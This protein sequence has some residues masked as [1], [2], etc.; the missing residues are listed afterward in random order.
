MELLS[1]DTNAKTIKGQK[2]G[3]LT[4]I[5]YLAPFKEAGMGNLCPM[6]SKGCAS[7]CLFTA[8]RGRFDNVKEARIKKTHFWFQEREK[9]LEILVRDIRRLERK[10]KKH[11]YRPACRLNGTSD[12]DFSKIRVGE[13]KNIYEM[14]PNV[15]FYGYSK[16]A[17]RFDKELTPN[18]HLTFSRSESNHDTAIELAKKGVNVAVVF[19][20]YIPKT[21]NGF[22]V[23][24][25]DET[26]LRFLDPKGVIC[27][28]IAKGKA[29]KDTSGFVVRQRDLKK[30]ID[31]KIAKV[32]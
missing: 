1:I 4:G 29:K 15:Q 21:W 17:S 23:F 20:K 27:G 25:A 6:A 3:Y 14:F 16:V 26:D 19:Q 12:L 9:F 5:L 10:A 31:K 32:L 18:D 11:G 7:A 13:F 28:L 24:N 2:H 22:K 30:A 8:G